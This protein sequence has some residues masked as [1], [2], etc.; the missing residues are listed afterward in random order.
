MDFPIDVAVHCADGLCGRSTYVLINP[1]FDKVTH[2]VVKEARPP[3]NE[4]VVP[5][6]LVSDTAPDAILLRCTSDGLRKTE[7]FVSRE[8]IK[9]KMPRPHGELAGYSGTGPYLMWPYTVPEETEYVPVEH[10]QIPPSELAV[11]RGTRV[12]ARD[13]HVGRVDE[14]VAN[15]ANGHITHLVMREG[16]LWGQK[17][18][19][20]PVSAIDRFEESTVHLKLD[21]RAIEALPEMRL[22]R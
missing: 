6:E 20:I 7:P 2:L 15:P 13:G 9:E 3:H 21:K 19:A 10:K 11:R 17:D 22:R 8:Y 18:V 16:H 5:I 14:F 4:Y 12:E 1:V